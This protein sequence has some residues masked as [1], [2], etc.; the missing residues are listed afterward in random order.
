MGIRSS[1]KCFCRL[2]LH[3]LIPIFLLVVFCRLGLFAHLSIPAK[4]QISLTSNETHNHYYPTLIPPTLT[5]RLLYPRL[6]SILHKPQA[7]S[8]APRLLLWRPWTPS[9]RLCHRR[10]RHRRSRT[11]EPIEREPQLDRRRRRGGWIL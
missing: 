11:R 8:Q 2:H 5:L 3:S 7:P 1:S 10:W 4:Y 9:I 6:H